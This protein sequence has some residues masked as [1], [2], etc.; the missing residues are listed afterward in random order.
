MTKGALFLS[1]WPFRAAK[2]FLA[3]AD[4]HSYIRFFP[5]QFPRFF[6]SSDTHIFFNVYSNQEHNSTS[7]TVVDAVVCTNHFYQFTTKLFCD[8][9]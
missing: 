9:A 6:V 3:V 2:H 7:T 1:S 5:F 4:L 8:C